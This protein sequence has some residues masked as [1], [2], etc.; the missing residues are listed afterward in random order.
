MSVRLFRGNFDS[1][2]LVID[3]RRG[4]EGGQNAANIAANLTNSPL[5]NANGVHRAKCFFLNLLVVVRLKN[6]S[7]CQLL[8]THTVGTDLYFK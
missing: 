7:L 6:N 4:G 5:R 2:R 3:G 8:G 1:R